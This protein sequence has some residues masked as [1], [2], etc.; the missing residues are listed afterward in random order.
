MRNYFKSLFKERYPYR[1]VYTDR[2]VSR[3]KSHKEGRVAIGFIIKGYIVKLRPIKMDA[4]EALVYRKYDNETGTFC[5]LPPLCVMRKIML[6]FIKVNNMIIELGGK[7][8][9]YR[10][11][12]SVNDRYISSPVNIGVYDK[13]IVGVH[14]RISTFDTVCCL[15]GNIIF[16]PAAKTFL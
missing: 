3:L 6:N 14:P 13:I 2:T 10:W 9:E 5:E 15:K 1:V 11:Y 4:E 8:F 7:S 16:Y 12:A